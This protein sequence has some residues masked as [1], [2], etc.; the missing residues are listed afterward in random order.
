MFYP[1]SQSRHRLC[2]QEGPT[3]LEVGKS[4]YFGVAFVKGW[5]S[6]RHRMGHGKDGFQVAPD[7]P[8]KEGLIL[9]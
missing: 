5:W 4:C 8:V 7:D 6:A 2:P 1:R 9:N 3:G